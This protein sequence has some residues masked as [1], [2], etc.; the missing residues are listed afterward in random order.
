VNGIKNTNNTSSYG[1]N[2]SVNKYVEDKY[3]F[4][5]SPSF[6]YNT[7]TSSINSTSSTRYWTM[8]GWAQGSLYMKK[9]L[10]INTNANFNF[11]QKDPRYP[12]N[13]NYIKWNA[14]IKQYVYKKELSIKFGINDILNQNR[15]YERNFSTYKF[16]ESY[17]NTLKRYWLLTLTW[18]FTHNKKIA[19]AATTTAAPAATEPI[20]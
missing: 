1:F 13:N 8:G 10:S 19:A 5:V 15:G 17:F 4:Y 2:F 16:T 3:D 7:S 12:Q 14:D 9:K 20:K 11:R 6:G 18:E